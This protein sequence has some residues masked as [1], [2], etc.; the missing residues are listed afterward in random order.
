MKISVALQ[1]GTIVGAVL[2]GHA[3]PAFAQSTTAKAGVAVKERQQESA[4]TSAGTTSK[5]VRTA[6]KGAVTNAASTTPKAGAD[7]TQKNVGA[8]GSQAAEQ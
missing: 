6:A 1:L 2:V 7:V 3:S 4:A 8:D 5:V